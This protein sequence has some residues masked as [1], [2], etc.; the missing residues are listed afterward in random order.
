MRGMR[1]THGFALI[2]VVAI[3]TGLGAG[4][5]PAAR[6]Q[7]KAPAASKDDLALV[8][9]LADPAKAEAAEAALAARGAEAVP[10]LI[11]GV[12]N[13]KSRAASVRLLTKLGPA[14]KAALPVLAMQVRSP[15]NPQLAEICVALGEIA[16]ATPNNAVGDGLALVVGSK[17]DTG[18]AEAIAS[19]SRILV[20]QG[21][22]ADMA[23]RVTPEVKAALDGL[24]GWLERHQAESGFWGAEEQKA[25]C[26]GATKCTEHGEAGNRAGVTGLALLALLR[27][28]EFAQTPARRAAADKAAKALREGQTADGCLG[29]PQLM[30]CVY[31]H[32]IAGE[33]LAEHFRSTQSA[34]SRAAVE[35]AVTYTLASQNAGAGWRYG[36]AD[37]DNDTSV[38]ARCAEFLVA[39]RDTGCADKAKVDAA[40]TGALAWVVSMT[41][42]NGRTGYQMTGGV[43]ARTTPMQD[44]FPNNLVEPLTACGIAVRILAPQTGGTADPWIPKS[45]ALLAEKPPAGDASAAAVDLYYWTHGAASVRSADPKLWQRWWPRLRA[46]VLANVE[47]RPGC[48]NGAFAATDPWTPEGG[49]TYLTA[50]AALCL[51][52]GVPEPQLMTKPSPAQVKLIAAIRS[53]TTAPGSPAKAAQTA[54]LAAIDLVFVAN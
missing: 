39:A 5:P 19:L 18:R 9:Q 26:K 45:L 1:F 2:A 17:K 21:T 36:R 50:M 24:L 4:L 33:A 20:R 22:P 8:A 14:A 34:E 35:K 28:P 38:T 37:N 13:Q 48:A 53:A 47:K 54:A 29:N 46:S 25:A 23:S 49:R 42:G 51:E 43:S 41:S 10:A 27:A 3:A 15:T 6:A 40:L 52:T 11:E 12:V 32:A 16:D 7:E 31:S 44:R 30:H